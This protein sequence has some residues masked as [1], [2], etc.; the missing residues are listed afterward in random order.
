MITH[1]FLKSHKSVVVHNTDVSD[2]DK[3]LDQLR[4]F[5][6]YRNVVPISTYNVLKLKS[7]IKDLSKFYGVPFEEANAATRTV[8]D[9]VRKATTKHGDDKNLFVLK[10]EEAIGYVC[11]NGETNAEKPVCDGCTP[12]CTKPVSPSFKSFLDNHP[13]I[14][15]SIQVLFKQN[16]SLGRHAG[17]VLIVDDLPNKMPLIT[18][19][20]EPQAPWQEGVTIKHLEY[21][22]NFIK[23]D[24]LGL[25]TMRLIERTIELILQKEGCYEIDVDGSTMKLSGNQE[26]LLTDGSW[27][28]VSNLS[29][30]H[31]VTSPVQ[32][33]G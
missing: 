8:E 7:L 13:Q 27:C 14:S 30:E 4:D 31:D 24:L 5:F 11:E 29:D 20:G 16:R 3:V 18:S 2:R 23:Y 6:G 15:E 9:D 32:I 17:G 26:V 21:I 22:G 10:Y 12:K 28:K 25:E 1:S 33:R 19:G